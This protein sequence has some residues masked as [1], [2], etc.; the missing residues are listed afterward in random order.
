[1]IKKFDLANIRE[2][3]AK[4][5]IKLLER[6]TASGRRQS[7]VFQDFVTLTEISLE[8][9]P[10]H[11]RSVQETGAMAADTPENQ[12]FFRDLKE[13]HYR[14]D[15]YW[16]NFSKSLALLMQATKEP[17]GGVRFSD[18][19]GEVF[20]EFGNPNPYS[21]Q[22]FTPFNLAQMMATMTNPMELVLERLNES[23]KG[24]LLDQLFQFR[25]ETPQANQFFFQQFGR[26]IARKYKPVTVMEPCC[27]SGVMFLALAASLPY[28]VTN[29][30]LVQFYG[31]DVCRL[32]V[33]MAKIN[34]MVH[35]LN[36]FGLKCALDLT[37]QELAALPEPTA[38]IYREAQAVKDDPEK[39]EEIKMKIIEG[40][41]GQFEMA[42]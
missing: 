40:K 13:Q 9:L 11:C 28:W 37:V 30:G 34:L 38:E 4:E 39:L 16:E 33:Q 35:G 5:I 31:Q 21:G 6:C 32:C 7:E 23:I 3:H 19:I 8:A 18:T 22:Y 25:P 2:G 24:T 36:G 15:F 20:M 41:R 12:K 14:T 42:F 10:L 17:G 29:Y 27:G 1:M 26:V